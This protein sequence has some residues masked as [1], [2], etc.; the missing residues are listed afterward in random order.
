MR[1]HTGLESLL[2]HAL[3]VLLI[4]L[5]GATTALPDDRQQEIRISADSA[6][7]DDVAGLTRYT[8]NVLL[9]QGSL[10]ISA[11]MISVS[12][13]RE[14]TSMIVAE[15]SPAHLSQLPAIDEAPVEASAERIEYSRSDD[16][17]RLL[18]GARIEQDGAIV[19]GETIDYLVSEQRVLA[20][21][22]DADTGKRVEVVI[23][24]EA[25]NEGTQ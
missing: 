5:S 12:H 15:G 4:V 9:V 2:R 22:G 24:P 25:L 23:P 3:G 8:G 7:R 10:R 17:V 21:A 20:S 14:Q 1:Q 6:A 19:S 18:R 13:D 16:L 11:D